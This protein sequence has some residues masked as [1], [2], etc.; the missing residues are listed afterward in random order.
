MSITVRNDGT[1]ETEEV[2]ELSMSTTEEVVG[3]KSMNA[4]L[5]DAASIDSDRKGEGASD[6]GTSRKFVSDT[7]AEGRRREVRRD[8]GTTTFTV[9]LTL[10]FPGMRGPRDGSMRGSRGE[11]KG[12]GEG[13]AE[14]EGEGDGGGR[15][16]A[17]HPVVSG[18]PPIPTGSACGIVCL[19]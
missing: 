3:N 10:V 15:T 2:G 7:V 11:G 19:N 17:G 8:V 13:E 4:K 6:S 14:A 5:L 18:P 16:K 9:S 12:E 1:K